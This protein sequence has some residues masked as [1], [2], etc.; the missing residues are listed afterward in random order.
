MDIKIV[1]MTDQQEAYIGSKEYK[2]RI[3]EFLMIEDKDQGDIL[4][5]IVEAHTYNRFIPMDENQGIPDQRMIENLR[6]VGFDLDEDTIYIGKVRLLEEGNY[7]IETGSLCR[8]PVFSE[9][10]SYFLSCTTDTG[11]TLGIIRNTEEIAKTMEE[12]FKNLCKTFQKGETLPQKDVPYLLNLYGMNEYPHIGIFGG[13][14]SGKS[15]GLRVILEELMKKEIPSLVLDPHYEMDFNEPFL[16]GYGRDYSDSFEKF[17]IGKNIGIEFTQINTKDLKNLLNTSSHLTE[18]MENVV[19]NLH[20]PKDS[21][22]TFRERIENL[23]AGQELGQESK[24][25]D[26]IED[27]VDQVEREKFEN[28]LEVYQKYNDKCP[29][30][31]VMA[32]YWRFNKLENLGIFNHNTD[33]CEGALLSRKL[34]VLQ[35]SI[36]IIQVFSTYLMNLFY[37]KRRAYRDQV[38]NGE[39]GDYF[40][41]F[42]VI[43]DE[44]HNFAPQSKDG[45]REIPSKYV[46]REIAQEGR[47]Y[48][49]FLIL[50]TQRPSLLDSTITAQLNTK[51]IFRTTR[52]TDIDTIRE[53]TDLSPEEARRLPYL[54]T[55]DVFVSESAVGR[56]VS[57]RIRAAHTNTPHKDNP[58]LELQEKSQSKGSD[59]YKLIIDYLPIYSDAL[60]DLGRDLQEEKHMV[61]SVKEL[62]ILLNEL[63]KKGMIEVDK[64]M[65]GDVYKEKSKI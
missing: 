61:F 41:P 60:L 12:E 21:L 25:R 43:T 64:S 52:A 14:G 5:E 8:I 56:T 23:R 3:N 17:T 26:R 48:G 38:I 36:K 28:I 18:A 10:K 6:E 50:A 62:Q 65:L 31:S 51:L 15:F 27:A 4:G 32:V 44:A 1:G 42:I 24:I 35:G 54:K 45:L 46:L 39:A 40:P 55:G 20:H 47:K 53:E 30:S 37:D 16:E 33:D 34:V 63:V 29:V 7:P 11:L 57:V 22:F 2:F 13:S 59:F 58:F 9:V 49:V 19:E